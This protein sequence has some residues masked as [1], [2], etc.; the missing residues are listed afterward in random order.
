[1]SF[2]RLSLALAATASLVGCAYV[3]LGNVP[4]LNVANLATGKASLLV[5]P[6]VAAGGYRTQGAA[7]SNDLLPYAKSD[8][9]KLQLSLFRVAN[10]TESA[11]V[12]A[13]NVPLTKEI[14]NASLDQEIGFTNLHPNTTYLV[15]AVAFDAQDNV[16]SEASSL[17]IAVAADERPPVGTLVVQLKNRL[18]KA[19]GTSSVVVTPGD[20]DTELE[21]IVV[22]QP[23]LGI[24]ITGEWNNFAVNGQAVPLATYHF[25]YIRSVSQ[26]TVSVPITNNG[27]S[28][29]TIGDLN[30]VG[31]WLP[32]APGATSSIT[33]HAVDGAIKVRVSAPI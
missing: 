25:D 18:F 14:L 12:N 2:A 24:L 27:T 1:M 3:P 28:T 7:P 21:D 4:Q 23:S 6:Q 29:F 8:V 16:I 31:P 5:R 10:G 22:A 32:V 33:A 17:Q 19:E 11:V 20:Y 15:K 30:N 13:S 26:A 9:A